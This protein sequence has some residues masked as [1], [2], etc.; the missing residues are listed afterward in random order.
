MGETERQIY[1]FFSPAHLLYINSGHLRQRLRSVVPPPLRFSSHLLLTCDRLPKLLLALRLLGPKE[2]NIFLFIYIYIYICIF[3]TGHPT[4][5][6]GLH[7]CSFHTRFFSGFQL[8][9]AAPCRR[10]RLTSLTRRRQRSSL[11]RV[12][13][14]RSVDRCLPDASMINTS[15]SC[16]TTAAAQR[17][18]TLLKGPPAARSFPFALAKA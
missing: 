3:L 16:R 5:G 18:S 12:D 10:R 8:S 15:L 1:L 7:L 14:Q 2:K 4:A 9:S 17:R 11:T 6:P 13:C